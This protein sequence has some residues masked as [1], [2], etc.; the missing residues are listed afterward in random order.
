M[1]HTLEM[2]LTV[3]GSVLAS[4]GFWQ[5][6]QARNDRNSAEHQALGALLR[7]EMF[8]IYER[9]KDSDSVPRDIQEEMDQLWQPYHAMG[10]NHMGDKIHNE[11]MQKKTETV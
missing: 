3:V 8:D 4:T 6:M 11:I 9:Y 10:Y 5:F 2:I 1:E 7:H